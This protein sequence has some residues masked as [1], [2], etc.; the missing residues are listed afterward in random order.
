LFK[1]ASHG[2][3]DHY[4]GELSYPFY[5]FHVF[6]IQLG[7]TA[8]RYFPSWPSDIAAWLGLAFTFALAAVAVPLELRFIEP[9]RTRFAQPLAAG[10]AAVS[11]ETRVPVTAATRNHGAPAHA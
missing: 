5:I 11:E 9:W 6:A 3:I 10:V 4:L 2:K 7:I 8:A 1:A